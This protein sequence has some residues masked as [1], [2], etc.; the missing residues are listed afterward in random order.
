MQKRVIDFSKYSS[1]KIGPSVDVLVI[2]EVCEIDKS[3]FIVGGANNLLVSNTPPPLAML[4][5]SFEYIKAENN[6]LYIGGA[7]SGGKILSFAKKHNIKGFEILQKL[8]GTLGGMLKMNAGLKDFSISDNLVAIKTYNKVLQKDECGFGYR[9]SKI[10]SLVFEA[11]FKIDDGFDFKLYESFKNARS[12]QPNLPSAGS[13]FKN[14]PNDFA[15]RVLEECGYKGKRL[16]DIGFSDM[17]ANFLVNYGHAT[18]DDAIKIIKEAKKSVF[19]K[20]KIDLELEI[21]IVDK[22]I[23]NTKI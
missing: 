10:D 18:F 23:S 20:F 6:L 21:Q 13:C 19:E 22:T 5:K 3:F 14:P 7:T 1:L 2:D 17:H 15:G 4:G 12:N 11:I 16:G 9:T 8:P